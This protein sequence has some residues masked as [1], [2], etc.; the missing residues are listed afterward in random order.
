MR[1]AITGISGRFGSLL[2]R[3]LHR[4]H[5]VVGLDRRPLRGAPIDVEM[6]RIDIRRKRCQEIFRKGK[7]DAVVH[8]NVVHDPRASNSDQHSFNIQGTTR[9]MEYCQRHGIAKL[10]LLSS[11][12]V[13]GPRADNAQFL[14][15]DAPLMA[16]EGFH[17]I[18]TLI[19]VDML[20]QS[21]FWK[22]PDVETVILR[23]VHILG[24]VHNAPSNYLRLDRPPVLAGFDPMIQVVHEDD[25]AWAIELA[26]QTGAQ[27][28]FNL[29]GCDPV[30]L[31]RLLQ[32]GGGKIVRFPHF[33][34][35]PVM[36]QLFRLRL[37]SFPP[38][39]IDHLRYV[40]MVDGGRARDILGYTP[41][42]DLG[43]T[44]AHLRMTKALMAATG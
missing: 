3:R 33:L 2:A 11:A 8:L 29:P 41:R 31:S 20:G 23:P 7:F 10:I 5:S 42:H 28:I 30:P 34:A 21:F 43:A 4:H 39:E 40:C 6:H 12:N 19:G 24:A 25:V 14:T 18:R 37:T 38:P 9:V 26:L 44:M 13:Y 32:M 22:N 36:E 35:L 15:E 17:Q 1:I 27:G 16:D